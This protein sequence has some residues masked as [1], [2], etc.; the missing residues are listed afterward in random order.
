MRLILVRHGETEL[1]RTGRI[2]GLNA[3]PLN[4][5]G[6]MQA[7]AVADALALD[8]PFALYSSPIARALETASTVS[9]RLGVRVTQLDGLQEADAG[10]LVGLTGVEM[11]RWYPDFMERW[12]ADA[13]TARMPGG[14]SMEEVQLRAWRAIDGLGTDRPDDTVVVVTHNQTIGTI[15]AT[16]LGMPLRYF[17]RISCALGSI[18]RLDLNV[19]RPMLVSLNET[20]HLP[21]GLAPDRTGDG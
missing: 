19:D 3:D 6:R 14:E 13:G 1:N 16:A 10:D 2:Q 8:M 18:T 20:W 4:E 17:R 21:K 12:A 5:S 15:V 9:S 7:Q 11:R